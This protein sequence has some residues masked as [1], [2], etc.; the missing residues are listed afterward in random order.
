MYFSY[1]TAALPYGAFLDLCLYFLGAGTMGVSRR[2]RADEN[3]KQQLELGPVQGYHRRRYRGKYQF[4]VLKLVT[5][6]LPYYL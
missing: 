4:E 3:T 2:N 1:L 5:F 6:E